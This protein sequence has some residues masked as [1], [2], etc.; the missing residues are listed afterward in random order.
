MSVAWKCFWNSIWPTDI[1]ISCCLCMCVCVCVCVCVR[2][3][4]Y[5]C[6]QVASTTNSLTLLYQ[7]N[8]MAS[9]SDWNSFRRRR[10][11]SRRLDALLWKS[12]LRDR[13]SRS[14]A[15]NGIFVYREEKQ[16]QDHR[17]SVLMSH[18]PLPVKHMDF[19]TMSCFMRSFCKEHK[20][21][22]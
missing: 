19:I 3:R 15:V 2:A 17:K 16:T 1:H 7:R 10:D 6:V 13:L 18:I 9:S 4:V 14:V 11:K 21:N 5:A 12:V 22:A 20:I 8:K